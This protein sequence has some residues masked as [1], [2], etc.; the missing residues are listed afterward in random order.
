MEWGEVC[1]E[2]DIH[3]ALGK[4]DAHKEGQRRA[5]KSVSEGRPSQSPKGN[6][7]EPEAGECPTPAISSECEEGSTKLHRNREL[8]VRGICSGRRGYSWATENFQ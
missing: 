3:R 5:D 8:G 4:E 1:K 2:A 7:A 6:V